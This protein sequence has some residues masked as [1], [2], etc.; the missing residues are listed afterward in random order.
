[1]SNEEPV[2]AAKEGIVL[3]GE[4]IKAAGDDPQVKEAARNLGKTAVTL[5]K[6]INNVLVP[7]AAINFAFDKARTYFSG[8]FQHDI[9]EKAQAIPQECIVEPKASIAGPTLQGLAFAHEE[10][11]LKEMYLNLLATAMDGR[12]ATDAHPA[13]VEIIKQLDS[14]DAGLVRYALQSSGGLGIVQIHRQYSSGGY[15]VLIR[16]LINLT[17]K[18]TGLP[19]EYTRLPAMV[20]N[21]IRLGLVDVEYDKFLTD[22]Y[23]YAWV[24]QRPELL[25]LKQEPLP[26]GETIEYQKG[27]LSRTELGMRFA[28]AIGLQ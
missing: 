20:D 15:N 28:K 5:T 23:N 11:N 4:V 6:A 8:T 26:E 21:W 27:I 19:V 17:S 12:A 10:P 7:L 24:E 2:K 1:M 9:A 22:P 18:L 3:I 13:F 25:R 14:D 16:H